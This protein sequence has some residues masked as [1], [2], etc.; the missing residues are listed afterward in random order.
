MNLKRLSIGTF[1]LLNL[2]EPGL[3]IYTNA[4]GWS[5]DQFQRKI[6]WTQH[7]IDLLHPDV[8]GFQEVVARGIDPACN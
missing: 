1:N 5:Q 4:A 8:F 6:D 3:P 2:N 7:I